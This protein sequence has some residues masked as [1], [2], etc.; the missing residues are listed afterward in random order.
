MR[1]C[2]CSP[3][4]KLQFSDSLKVVDWRNLLTGEGTEQHLVAAWK[5]HILRTSPKDFPNYHG[6]MRELCYEKRWGLHPKWLSCLASV[7]F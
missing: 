2:C 6:I 7:W 5:W 4:A 1:E 3:A